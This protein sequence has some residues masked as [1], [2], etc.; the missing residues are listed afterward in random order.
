M[1]PI[2]F[3]YHLQCC[4]GHFICQSHCRIPKVSSI[5]IPVIHTLTSQNNPNLFST[6]IIQ[7]YTS[8]SN[9]YKLLF[10]HIFWM[11]GT[12][13]FN[14]SIIKL[15]HFVSSSGKEHA[16]QHRRCKRHGFDPWVRKITWRRALHP[17]P[18]LVPGESSGQRSLVGTIHRVAK[19]WTQLKWLSMHILSNCVNI[20]GRR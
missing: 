12:I 4:F 10:I 8:T 9:V 19:S 7:I 16:W 1:L 5:Y 3:P 14:H 15:C 18:V 11:L 13:L 2:F 17:T 20:R 6:V